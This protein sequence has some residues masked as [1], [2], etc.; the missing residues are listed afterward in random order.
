M[1]VG[2]GDPVLEV[3]GHLRRDRRDLRDLM[4]QRLRIRS[5]TT[6][7]SR[8]PPASL[9]KVLDSRIDAFGRYQRTP[10]PG[11]PLLAAWTAPPACTALLPVR[12]LLRIGPIA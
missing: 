2:A 12:L 1:T 10:M 4:L 7:I 5:H 6:E 9:R 11:M 3:C 8:A